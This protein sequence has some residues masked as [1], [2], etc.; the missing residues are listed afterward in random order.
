MPIVGPVVRLVVVPQVGAPP[1]NTGGSTRPALQ[2]HVPNPAAEQLAHALLVAPAHR[3]LQAG[4]RGAAY[5][6]M[7]AKS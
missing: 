2:A 7:V 5:G 6:A 4:R 1:A 3:R